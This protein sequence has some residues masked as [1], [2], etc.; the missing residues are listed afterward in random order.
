MIIH[1]S[2]Q[3]KYHNQ[4]FIIIRKF[5]CGFYISSCYYVFIIL[6]I[7][8]FNMVSLHVCAFKYSVV[9]VDDSVGPHMFKQPWY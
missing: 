2:L 7:K 8:V 5:D 6:L 3:N 9:G 4:S 1:L